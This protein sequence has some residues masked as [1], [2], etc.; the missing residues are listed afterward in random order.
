MDLEKSIRIRHKCCVVTCEE[1]DEYIT[2]Q[3]KDKK[4]LEPAR[5]AAI[6]KSQG[7]KGTLDGERFDSKWECLVWIYYKKIQCVPCER[8][9]VDSVAYTDSNGQLRKFYPDF[10]VNGQFVEVKGIYR[11]DDMCKMEQHPEI[12]F[13]DSS[14]IEPIKKEVEKRFPNWQRDY[15]PRC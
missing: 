15:M 7:E 9:H 1:M 13:I 3:D 6:H 2:E 14:N 10:K 11:P 8:N 5:N 4:V 12:Q